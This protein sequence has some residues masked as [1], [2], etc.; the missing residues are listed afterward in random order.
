MNIYAIGTSHRHAPLETRERLV[1][2]DGELPRA[3]EDL[4]S[5][6]ASEAVI[7]S[8]CNRTEVYV[9]PNDD[10]FEH[11]RLREWLCAW[12]KASLPSAQTF[13]LRGSGAARHLFEVAAGIDSQVIGDIQI[14]GQVRNSYEAARAHGATGKLLSRLFTSAIHTGK[15]VK[16][17]TVLFSGAVSISYVA[18]EL[19]RKIFY[20][21][22][23][24]RTL[25]IGAGSSGEMAARNLHDQGV[26]DITITNR[27]PER[28]IA[29]IE[30]LGFGAWIPLEEMTDSLGA[31]D[32]VIVSTGASEYLI[33]YQ[34]ARAAI[35]QRD[36]ETMLIVDISVPRNVDP[37]IN[38][39]PAIFCKDINDLNSV[40]ESNVE[41]RRAEIPRADMIIADELAKFS[42]WCNLLPVTPVI[43]GLKKRA[44]EIARAEI[45]RNRHRFD[46]ETFGDVE[47][48]VGSV[49]RRLISMPMAHLLE[50]QTDSDRAMLKAEYVRLLFNLDDPS[51]SDETVEGHPSAPG[52][53]SAPLN[54]AAANGA[55]TNQVHRE[56]DT[57]DRTTPGPHA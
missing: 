26:R 32:I 50:A 3:L 5:S 22:S 17:E 15:R 44:E 11:E 48:L 4:R 6:L 51:E 8:T 34:D 16:S 40:V 57:T 24:K 35:S 27:T 14:I 2:S 30:R 42:A 21:I 45:E 54:G 12:K 25:V 43:A 47:K 38:T 23:E 37:R 29:L 41:R 28:G 56:P 7:I 9:V 36:G 13:A 46:E 1:F 52:K 20:P 33:T 55:M 39:I 10:Y 19:A 53:V 18:V 49:V 31:F